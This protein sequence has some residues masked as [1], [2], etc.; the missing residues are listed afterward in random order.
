MEAPF[1]IADGAMDERCA[2]GHLSP[3]D[4][5]FLWQQLAKQTQV[6]R[7][8]SKLAIEA[9]TNLAKCG[10]PPKIG[11]FVKLASI[12]HRRDGLCGLDYAA[13]KYMSMCI[14]E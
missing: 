1:Q 13:F 10:H 5:V 2:N 7:A 14:E 3:K 8:A 11:H 12:A 4:I 9:T 6:A